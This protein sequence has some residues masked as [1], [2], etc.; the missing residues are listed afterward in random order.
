MVIHYSFN[1]KEETN[2]IAEGDLDLGAR[3]YSSA[4]EIFFSLDPEIHRIPRISPYSYALDNPIL[5][6]DLNG[7]YP[8]ICFL[9]FEFEAGL[10]ICYGF[11]YLVQS[12]VAYDEVGHTHF[13]VQSALYIWNQDLD[14]GS[15]KPEIVVGGSISATVNC[16]WNWERETFLGL[17]KNSKGVTGAPVA[18]PDIPFKFGYLVAIN[19]GFNS[20]SFTLGV[21]PGIGAKITY[22]YTGIVESISFTDDESDDAPTNWDVVDAKPIF[23]A[24]GKIIEYEGTVEG[25]DIKVYSQPTVD[26]AGKAVSNNIWMSRE[27]KKQAEA[28]EAADQED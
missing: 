8:G 16:S 24:S 25:T 13:T 23:D 28:A 19:L 1:G 2:E 17:I 27:Y 15:K 6:K 12:G 21:G 10:G 9:N 18:T 4:L 7:S 26:K 14:V 20:E 11:N 22:L 3:I 5:L